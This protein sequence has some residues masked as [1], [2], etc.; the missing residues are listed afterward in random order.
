M[1]LWQVRKELPIRDVF[2]GVHGVCMCV[3]VCLWCVFG[4]HVCVHGACSA[5]GFVGV[6]VGVR[7]FVVLPGMGI[8][9]CARV[10]SQVCVH[11]HMHGAH[12]CGVHVCGVR[13]GM[14]RC[15][16]VWRACVYTGVYGVYDMH[17]CVRVVHVCARVCV[18]CMCV[19]CMWVCA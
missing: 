12:V 3:H 9:V 7:V 14:C 17:V 18:V 16:C 6:L 19:V 1:S 5:L 2:T 8:K 11:A 15:E 10:S 13:V 4:T